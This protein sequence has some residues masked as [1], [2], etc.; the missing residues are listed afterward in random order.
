M[1]VFHAVCLCRPDSE[2]SDTTG[3]WSDICIGQTSSLFW[4]VGKWPLMH[5][6]HTVVVEPGLAVIKSSTRQPT[7]NVLYLSS[8]LRNDY[9]LNY[10]V[11]DIYT[12]YSCFQ[13]TMFLPT[14][15]R[16]LFMI[17]SDI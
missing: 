13:K 17:H 15:Q 7:S 2:S 10:I 8:T 5:L 4:I 14:Y 12:L 9:I 11:N 3:I 1:C 6:S 16:G